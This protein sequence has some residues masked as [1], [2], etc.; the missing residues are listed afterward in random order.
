LLLTSW[1]G[2]GRPAG[3]GPC[4]GATSGYWSDRP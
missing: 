1:E 3:D 2:S 4:G